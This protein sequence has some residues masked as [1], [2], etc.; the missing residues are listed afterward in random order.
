MGFRNEKSGGG[1]H[2]ATPPPLFY[3]RLIMKRV[4][5]V[6]AGLFLFVAASCATVPKTGVECSADERFTPEVV[7]EKA[8]AK[9][10]EYLAACDGDRAVA[11]EKTAVYLRGLRGIKEVKV[12]GSDT[13][14]VIMWDG[15]ELLLMLGKDRL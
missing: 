10:A 15:N 5:M 1:G 11:T 6:F 9:Y 2:E 12:R 8:E 3:R 7:V 13:L 14:F 4:F